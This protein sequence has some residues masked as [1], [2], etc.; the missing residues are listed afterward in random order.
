MF[1]WALEN[2]VTAR[3]LAMLRVM[4]SITDKP[5][6]ETK[7]F[8]DEIVASWR[9]GVVGSADEW[10]ISPKAWNWCLRELRDEASG[11]ARDGRVVVYAV[12]ARISK[13]QPEIGRG[14]ED[15]SSEYSFQY[16][17]VGVTTSWE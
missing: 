4:N 15:H 6:W 10:L 7:I 14:A 9:A 3:E 2:R 17:P 16:R 1:D 12:G 8:D 11:Y 13:S 5:G